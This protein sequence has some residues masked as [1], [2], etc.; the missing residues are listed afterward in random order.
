MRSLPTAFQTMLDSGRQ[1]LAFCWEIVRAD[2]VTQRFTDFEDDI[3][4]SG[5]TYASVAGFK[6][7]AISFSEGLSADNLDIT[8]FL[9]V[10]SIAQADILAGVYDYA[11]ITVSL[12]NYADT[13][14]GLIPLTTGRIGDIGIKRNEFTAELNGLTQH[15]EQSFGEVT[16]AA[17]R[18][19]LGDARCGKSLTGMNTTG[20]VTSV[21]NSGLFVATIGSSQPSGWWDG[22]AILWTLGNNAGRTSEV[23]TATTGT[24]PTIQ[25]HLPMLRAVQVGDTFTLSPGC[26]HARATCVSKFSNG[27]R[28]VGEPDLPGLDKMLQRGDL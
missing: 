2:A 19:V 21:T 26:D 4:V 11:S 27:S 24:G 3:V 8:G 17:C 23:K 10:G 1:T 5:N 13:T 14:Q 18:A 20:T 6:R 25:L 9:S 28:F 22:G 12:V 7:T 16:S 15:L